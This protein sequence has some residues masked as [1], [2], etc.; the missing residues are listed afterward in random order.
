MQKKFELTLEKLNTMTRLAKEDKNAKEIGVAIGVSTASVYKI[1][2][3]KMCTEV[4]G[5]VDGAMSLAQFKKLNGVV[6]KHKPGVQKGTK[7]TGKRNK[8]L[9]KYDVDAILNRAKAGMDLECIAVE[10]AVAV[11]QL[12]KLFSGKIYSRFTH[13]DFDMSYEKFCEIHKVTP[14]EVDDI[15]AHQRQRGVANTNMTV[16]MQLLLKNLRKQVQPVN[17]ELESIDKELEMYDE[18][19]EKLK[20]D[21]A[22]AEKRKEK[23]LAFKEE[24]RSSLA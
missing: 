19:I 24:V 11:P 9:T 15:L 7:R 14:V 20:A 3:G 1:F 8:K 17:E 2:L 21:K 23:L 12:K 22:I 16:Q 18:K 5:F 6:T 10:F 4:T 13:F